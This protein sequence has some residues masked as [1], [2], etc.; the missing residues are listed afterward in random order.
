MLIVV[1]MGSM[2]ASSEILVRLPTP[3]TWTCDRCH[4][5]KKLDK[6]DSYFNCHEFLIILI[7]VTDKST[8]VYTRAS[9][10]YCLLRVLSMLL[11]R[12]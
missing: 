9:L 10:D 1:M 3:V 5:T 11:P 8:T 2:M 6:Q 12:F 4:K 7:S